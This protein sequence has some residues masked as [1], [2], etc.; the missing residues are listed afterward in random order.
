MS[1]NGIAPNCFQVKSQCSAIRHTTKGR[2]T[3]FTPAF[4]SMARCSKCPQSL[5]GQRIQCS[6][7]S[8]DVHEHVSLSLCGSFRVAVCVEFEV[9]RQ[10]GRT[11]SPVRANYWEKLW[12]SC[13]RI[14]RY[15][16]GSS[17]LYDLAVRMYFM[18]GTFPRAWRRVSQGEW[19]EFPR[20]KPALPL[21][22][23]S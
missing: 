6:I 14:L 15:S 7:G 10:H 19:R 16:R 4:P 21:Q 18:K 11:G 8:C 20:N 13:K 12:A 9:S 23:G 17:A 5:V 1:A 3:M 22:A 2:Q